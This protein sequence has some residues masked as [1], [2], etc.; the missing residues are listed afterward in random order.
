[1]PRNI[2]L[3][4]GWGVAIILSTAPARAQL[5]LERQTSDGLWRLALSPEKT[6]FIGAYG[7]YLAPEISQTWNRFWGGSPSRGGGSGNGG[8]SN[9]PQPRPDFWH[10]LLPSGRLPRDLTLRYAGD[11]GWNASLMFEPSSI[12]LWNGLSP[13]FTLSAITD[14]NA[15]RAFAPSGFGILLDPTRGFAQAQ[16][17]AVGGELSLPVFT[18]ANASGAYTF[19]LGHGWMAE[20]SRTIGAVNSAFL[21]L[22][23]ATTYHKVI[24]TY[25]LTTEFRPSASGSFAFLDVPKGIKF[26]GVDFALYGYKTEY[27]WTIGT[28]ATLVWRY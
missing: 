1:M 9:G 18:T 8:S 24:Q 20:W 28:S 16:F 26:S 17:A 10:I 3:S 7:Q 23:Y 11:V 19:Y 22:S 27:M 5:S 15:M 21:D 6:T 14:T 25:S 2:V 12:V 13:R 4:V